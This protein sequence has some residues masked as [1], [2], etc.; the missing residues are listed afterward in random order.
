MNGQVQ[1]FFVNDSGPGAAGR[2]VDSSDMADAWLAA[3]GTCVVTDVVRV[4]APGGA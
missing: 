4:A 2:F 3:G 1:G